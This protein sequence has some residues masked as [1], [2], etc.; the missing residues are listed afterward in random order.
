[1][2]DVNINIITRTIPATPRSK[3]YPQGYSVTRNK[4]YVT[5]EVKMSNQAQSR[6]VSQNQ[7]DIVQLVRENRENVIAALMD[8]NGV[9]SVRGSI[10][11]TGSIDANQTF[12]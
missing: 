1:M 3:N 12:E 7:I 2:I 10:R 11:A 5:T 9:L 4:R 6:A 8:G